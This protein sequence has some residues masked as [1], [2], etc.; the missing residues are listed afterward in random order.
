[1]IRGQAEGLLGSI[2]R[3]AV[4]GDLNFV[5]TPLVAFQMGC[6]LAVVGSLGIGLKNMVGLIQS[7]CKVA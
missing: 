5:G 4:V 7:F 2:D 3:L 1:M 6:L